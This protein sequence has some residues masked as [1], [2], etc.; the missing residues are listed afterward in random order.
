MTEHGHDL[1]TGPVEADCADCGHHHVITQEAVDKILNK[2]RFRCY[3]CRRRMG[4]NRLGSI[5]V[6]GTDL[7]PVC[8]ACSPEE[9]KEDIG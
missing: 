7:K 6:W 2:R 1:S 8:V 9:D 4:R 3:R 5:D